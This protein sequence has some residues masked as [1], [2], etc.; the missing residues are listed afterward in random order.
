MRSRVVLG[1]RSSGAHRSTLAAT[2]AVLLLA[3]CARCSLLAF[4]PASR[5]PPRAGSRS[6]GLRRR[7]VADDG[8]SPG[9]PVGQPALL[10]EEGAVDRE[11]RLRTDT[12]G[13]P[14]RGAASGR[15]K[16]LDEMDV[17]A[18]AVPAAVAVLATLGVLAVMTFGVVGGL[19]EAA[20]ERLAQGPPPQAS[21]V[22]PP[23]L[24]AGAAM[25]LAGTVA[26][27]ASP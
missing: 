21:V 12:A 3:A 1:A 8:F 13:G 22:R 16:E 18:K 27:N 17:G 7:A 20:K 6:A 5:A 4:L 15:L 9:R 25:P 11:L 26:K 2:A 23:R 24:Q 19:R 10:E 14:G